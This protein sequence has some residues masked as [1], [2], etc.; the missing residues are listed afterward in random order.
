MNE[1]YERRMARARD[2]MDRDQ[3]IEAAREL[4]AASR[5]APGRALAWCGLAE[6]ARRVGNWPQVVR[7]LERAMEAEPQQMQ[8]RVALA[9]AYAQLKQ[10]AT[11]RAVLGGALAD[12]QSAD[13][14][15]MIARAYASYGLRAEAAQ[16]VAAALALQPDRVE[17]LQLQAHLAVALGDAA[18]AET[19][20]QRLIEL[21]PEQAE[22]YLALAQSQTLRQQPAA[23]RQTFQTAV[24]RQPAAPELWAGLA[25]S[26]EDFGE[27]DEAVQAYRQALRLRPGW[28]VAL[29]GLLGLLAAQ[30]EEALVEQAQRLLDSAQLADDDRAVLGYGL[31][32]VYDRRQQPA[33]AFACW[34][35]ANAARRRSTGPFDRAHQQQRVE[36]TR[37]VF[38]Q[39]FFAQRTGWGVPDPR[40]VFVIGLPRSGT[41]LVE[42]ILAAHPQVAGFG[43]LPDIARIPT[44]IRAS[45]GP[46]EW[47]EAATRLQPAQVQALAE[48]YLARLAEIQP[49]QQA[50][51][52]VDKAPLNFMHVGLIRLLFPAARIVWCERDP[53]DVAL[54]IYSE[55]FAHSQRH[56]TDLEDLAA[57]QL[58]HRRLMAHWLQLFGAAI[59]RIEYAALIEE[60]ESRVRELVAFLDL[61]WDEACLRFHESRREVLTP[62]R[63]QV[64]QPLYRHA[65]ERWRP[66]ETQLAPFIEAARAGGLL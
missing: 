5:E 39:T 60:P 57:Y 37:Q 3:V 40:P 54:S 27:R 59:H 46:L 53:R 22:H 28:P 43:E 19:S 66:Y 45:E 47:P 44:R 23:A 58:Q 65:L 38:D 42:Q 12:S 17:A 24:Q 49:G 20:W 7:H 14:R 9:G 61:P 30:A 11:V 18:L 4:E 64:R 6:L 29:G 33:A 51:R 26:A 32:R 36:R 41:S 52:W 35:Q 16:A 55:N 2:L 13:G 15:L 63:W 34:S 25:Q 10:P 48:G 1:A 21:Q 8:H 62:S 50:Q 56:A 31:G